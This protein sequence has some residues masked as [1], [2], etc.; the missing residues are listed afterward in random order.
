MANERILVVDDEKGVVRSCVRILQRLDFFVSGRTDSES[1]FELLQQETFDLLLTDIRMPRT[2]G[3]ELL[4]LAKTIDPHL[5]VVLITGYGTMDDAIRAIRLGA[6]GFLMKPFEPEEY[7]PWY[8]S[9]GSSPG[10]LT[11]DGSE[12]QEPV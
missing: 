2:D 6:Q 5:S 12:S 9:T 3:L 11:R 8:C 10:H 4:R 1:A 7:L